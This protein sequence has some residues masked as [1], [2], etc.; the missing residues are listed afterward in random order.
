MI[1]EK[2]RRRVKE[3]KPK[4]VLPA[5]DCLFAGCPCF[6]AVIFLE[7][8]MSGLPLVFKESENLDWIIIVGDHD[9]PFCVAKIIDR[10]G[11]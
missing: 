3:S 1:P 2:I 11:F 7:G 10:S 8:E 4:N 6:S 5:R 9:D